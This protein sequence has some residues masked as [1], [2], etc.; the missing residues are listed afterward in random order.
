MAMPAPYF[1]CNRVVCR[2]M[3]LSSFWQSVN[4]NA[5]FP[6]GSTEFHHLSSEATNTKHVFVGSGLIYLHPDAVRAYVKIIII[7]VSASQS[8]CILNFWIFKYT[9]LAV[10]YY[11]ES[12][13]WLDTWKNSFERFKLLYKIHV[14]SQYLVFKLFG[15]KSRN[16]FLKAL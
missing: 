1:Y 7:T 11:D 8:I 12:F 6:K 13:A 3:A 4:I 10:F 5:N 15:V 9:Y 14:T 16:L 2:S